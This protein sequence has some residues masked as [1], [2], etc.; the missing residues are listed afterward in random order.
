MQVRN[1]TD[2]EQELAVCAQVG[3]YL[4]ENAG[5]MLEGTVAEYLL[6][7][8]DERGLK[9]TDVIG[10]SGLNDIY[11][12]QI[13]SGKRT[14]SRDKLLC[15]CFGM[16]LT[17]DETQTLLK[18]CGYPTLYAKKRRDSIILHALFHK[19]SLMQCNEELYNIGEVLLC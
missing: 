19:S 4:D 1:T 15:L 3:Q 16:K 17:S 9:R 18:Q 2:L 10:A 12:H 5:Q 14:P 11:A 7:L 6:R 13:F 8:L